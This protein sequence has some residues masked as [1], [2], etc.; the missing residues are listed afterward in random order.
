MQNGAEQEKQARNPRVSVILP[1]RNEARHIERCLKSVL[2]QEPPPGG[3]EIIIADGKSTDRTLE[4]LRELARMDPR[5][6]LQDDTQSAT[7]AA[8]SGSTAD[9][10]L[11]SVIVPCRN[12]ID[13][14]RPCIESLLRQQPLPCGFEI[15]VA[16]GMSEDGTRSVLAELAQS[17]PRVRVI[18]NPARGISA[19]LN[20][21]IRASRGNIIIRADAHSD[22]ADDYLVCCVETLIRT[23]ADNVG[24]PARTRVRGYVQQA[25]AAAYHA[26]MVVGG[27][28]F[29]QIG[30]AGFV[31]TVTY[32]C[33]RRAIFTRVGLFDETL[34][35]N[36]D[37]ELNLR[38]TRSGGKIWQSPAIRSWYYPRQTLDSLFQQYYQYG[39]WKV[40]VIRK[41]RAYAS[42]RHLIPGFMV[43]S[44]ML[45]LLL[46]PF[47]N[48]ARLALAI[49]IAVYVVFVGL[50]SV[51]AA[52]KKGWR[53]LPILP[54]VILSFHLSYGIGFLFGF[55]DV[56]LKRTPPQQVEKLTR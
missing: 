3:F 10:G 13:Y 33:W 20:A 34:A 24:G 36:E 45:G 38:I 40:H 37:D 41:H 30:H 1:C 49:G 51:Q 54:V 17:D 42:I 4:I 12:E 32:G 23:G 6:R 46:S 18:D 28:R 26:P 5:V 19:G 48:H 21:A 55:F 50:A 15:I 14:I 2:D 56:F 11:V 43:F 29:H 39:Y 53:L 8:A 27:A 22:Y 47:S 44:G 52:R 31:D 25:V 16:D 35:R 9:I 7:L